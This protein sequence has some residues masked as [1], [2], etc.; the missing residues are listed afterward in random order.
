MAALEGAGL[1]VSGIDMLK[2]ALVRALARVSP[3]FCS[4][5]TTLPFFPD[6]DVVTLLDVIEHVD[7]DVSVLDE[8]RRVL[9]PGGHAIVTVPGPSTYDEVIGHKRRP[10]GRPSLRHSP[11]AFR[12]A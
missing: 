10:I 7:D 1:S 6:F 12:C 3:L 5:A 11:G 2:S 4:T 9:A 8:A